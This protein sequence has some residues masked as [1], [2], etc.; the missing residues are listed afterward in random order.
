MASRMK[1]RKGSV[2]RSPVP[3]RSK[4]ST[5]LGSFHGMLAALGLASTRLQAS[6]RR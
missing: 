3:R 4:K 1:S 5:G 6:R 2:R